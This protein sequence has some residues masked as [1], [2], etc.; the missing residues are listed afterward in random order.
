MNRISDEVY[1][2]INNNIYNLEGERWWDTDFSL[3]LIKTLFN[4]FRVS[5][6]KKVISKIITQEPAYTNLLEVGC[7]GGL[8]S[9]E[10]A[11]MGFLTTGIDPSDQSL[12]AA[13]KHA[14]QNNLII[15]YDKGT[16]EKLPYPSGSF[17]VVLCCDVLE[18][19]Q[20][21]PEVI[22]EISR[23]LKYDGVFVYDTF[24]RTFMSRLTAIKVLQEWSQWAIMPPGLHVWEMF[25]KPAEIR[26]LLAKNNL[27]WREHIGIKP[28]APYLKMLKY[29][30]ERVKGKLSYEEFGSKFRMVESRSTQIMYMGHAVKIKHTPI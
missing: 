22:S 20:D 11:R 17:D 29:L 19:V 6:A 4:P 8:L 23:V 24:N 16:G 1:S 5:Y 27:E 3:N 21:L 12:L 14:R 9:E 26:S 30:R 15:K 7:G 2:R 13:I 28:G 18:H 10:F 25:I